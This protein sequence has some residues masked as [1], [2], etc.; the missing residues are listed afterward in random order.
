MP[1]PIWEMNLIGDVLPVDQ[2]LRAHGTHSVIDILIVV[3]DPTV[4]D[5]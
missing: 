4:L 3:N 2:I 5:L 1:R